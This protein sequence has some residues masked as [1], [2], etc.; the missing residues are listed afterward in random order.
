[1]LVERVAPRQGLGLLD[2]EPDFVEILNR[3]RRERNLL[4]AGLVSW[5]P[6]TKEPT[7]PARPPTNQLRPT[8]G[9]TSLPFMH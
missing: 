6:L 8:G 3:V 4:T 5:P 7:P 1:M 2:N 9:F